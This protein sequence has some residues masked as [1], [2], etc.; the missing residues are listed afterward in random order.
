MQQL[1]TSIETIVWQ[2][3][4]EMDVDE[5]SV[6]FTKP[7]SKSNVTKKRNQ[8]VDDIAFSYVRKP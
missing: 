5:E 8:I 7:I 4:L 6:Q 1:S 3:F 2:R